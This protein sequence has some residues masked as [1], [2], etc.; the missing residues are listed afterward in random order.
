[1]KFAKV[2]EADEKP[3][4]IVYHCMN[5]GNEIVNPQGD[6][7]SRRFCSEKCK[8]QYINGN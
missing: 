5:C 7:Y 6:L 1:M 2:K 3:R 4:D 8:K